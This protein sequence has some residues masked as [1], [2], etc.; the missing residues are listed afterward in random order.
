MLKIMLTAAV[1]GL[2]A[3]FSPGPLMALVVAQTLQYGVREGIMVAAAPILTDAPI[4]V[5]SIL[6]IGNLSST[7]PVIGAIAALGALYVLYLAYETMTIK[8][9]N[10][11]TTM[12]RPKSLRKGVL[13]NALSPHPYLFW[14]TVGGP[15]MVTAWPE[16]TGGPWLF[17]VPF[18]GLLIGSKIALSLIMG[19]FR[20]FLSGPI[21]LTAMR[22]LGAVLAVFGLLLLGDSLKHFSLI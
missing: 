3:G 2:A 6:I 15:Y 19:K 7:G 10:L 9:I 21:Y 20:S 22:L 17:I 16:A 12:V 18:Y 14:I 5:L 1:F 13:V 4:I 11:E 8:P